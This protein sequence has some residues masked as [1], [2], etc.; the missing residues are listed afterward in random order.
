[1]KTMLITFFDIKGIV[2]FELIL[3][4]L[5]VSWAYYI[6]ILKRLHEAVLRESFE[7]GP[8]DLIIYHDNAPI[9]RALSVEQF[10]TQKS[11]KDNS[12]PFPSFAPNDFGSFQKWSVP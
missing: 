6:Q 10:L 8:N 12:H 7:V 4:G 1:M 11:I 3:Q 9:H 5:T 2:H